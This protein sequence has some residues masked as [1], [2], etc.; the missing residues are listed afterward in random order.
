VNGFHVA[1]PEQIKAGAVADVY[2]QRTAAILDAKG[3]DAH[4]RAEFMAKSLPEDWEWAVFA[5]LAEVLH[6]LEGIDV[7]VRAMDE[8][9]IFRPYEPVLE[10][11]GSYSDFGV[12]ETA[13]LGLICQASG[14][15]TRA[16][17]CRKA[18]GPD[19]RL[20][21][22]G[23]RR[24]HPAIAPMIERAAY[25]GGCDGVAVVAS[26]ELLGTEPVGTIP[27]ALVLVMGD[28]VRATRAFDEVIEKKVP[29]I[30]LIDTFDDEKFAALEVAAALG[31]RLGA[32]RLDTPSSRRGDFHEIL[33]EVRWELDLRGYTD[34]DL[35]VSGGIDEDAIRELNPVADGYGVGTWISAAPVVDFAMDI[36]EIDGEPIAKRGKWSGAKQVLR[37]TGCRTDDIVPLHQ[38]EEWPER[39][40]DCGAELESLLSL[41]MKGGQP[42]GPQPS[43]GEIRA[44]TLER[45]DGFDILWE[46]E[47]G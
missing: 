45:L 33:R 36:V 44:R 1:T 38:V 28:T 47:L 23:A 19:R 10:I 39:C 14:I 26:A 6:L 15:A 20:I 32:L 37:C 9:A 27:H 2:F 35:F 24:M 5:G 3:V 8:G 34:V 29:R 22:F 40:P 7:S 46:D 16:A 12:Y 18:A 4:V 13:A 25:L 31:P 30:S 41:R 21:S 17:R 42:T 43:A 11:E